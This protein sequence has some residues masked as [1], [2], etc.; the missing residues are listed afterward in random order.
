MPNN[1]MLKVVGCFLEYQ[2]KFVILQRAIHKPQGGTW[3]LPAGKVDDGESLTQAM[4]REIYEETGLQFSES[5]LQ[6]LGEWE[7]IDGQKYLFPTFLIRLEKPLE[8]ALN[9]KEHQSHLWITAEECD[10]RTDLIKG[11]HTLLRLTR[12]INTPY[13]GPQNE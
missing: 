4:V 3:G 1:A 13:V 6:Y 5:Q 8:V 7:F 2:G 12:Y 11:F 10:T 9:S